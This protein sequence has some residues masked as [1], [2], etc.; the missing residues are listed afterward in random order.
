MNRFPALDAQQMSES[1][2]Q[3]LSAAGNATG[4]PFWPMLRSPD[5]ARAAKAVRLALRDSVLPADLQEMAILTIAAA[6]DCPGQFNAHLPLARAAGLAEEAIEGSRA[7]FSLPDHLGREQLI[8]T[9]C[10]ELVDRRQLSTATW[11]SLE[12]ALGEQ[13]VVELIGF[14]GFYSWMAMVMNTDRPNDERRSNN[15]LS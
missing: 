15:E 13:A 6:C 12:Q 5:L 3:L 4:G 9:A 2:H 7:E 14:A 8:R 10:R 1:Q 11:D